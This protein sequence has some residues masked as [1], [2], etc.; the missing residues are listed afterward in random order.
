LPKRRYQ[1]E[2]IPKRK[3]T[4]KRLSAYSNLFAKKKIPKSRDTK[5]NFQSIL[6]NLPKRRY[7]KEFQRLKM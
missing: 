4:K 7:Q 2:K 6:T 1:K 3:D 5:K